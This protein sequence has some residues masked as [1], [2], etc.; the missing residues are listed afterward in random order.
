MSETLYNLMVLEDSIVPKLKK[1]S[2]RDANQQDLQMKLEFSIKFIGRGGF[3]FLYQLF[4]KIPKEK[5][6]L[7]CVRTKILTLIV[8]IVYQFFLSKQSA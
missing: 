5:L 7:D 4:N 2:S 3:K 6:E 8:K 1:F